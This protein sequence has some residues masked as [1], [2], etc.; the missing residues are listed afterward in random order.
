M[1]IMS[2]EPPRAELQA[3][4]AF[5]PGVAD[6]INHLEEAEVLQKMLDIIYNSGDLEIGEDD[7][8]YDYDIYDPGD[9]WS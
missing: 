9:M 6:E 5:G 7:E 4:I 2:Y 8:I 3:A 1:T